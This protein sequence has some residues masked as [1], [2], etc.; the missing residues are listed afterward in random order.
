MP[1]SPALR[2]SLLAALALLC[3]FALAAP[4][5]ARPGS[6]G[7]RVVRRHFHLLVPHSEGREGLS[8]VKTVICPRH[9][10]VLGGGAEVR[11]EGVSVTLSAPNGATDGWSAQLA[12][13]STSTD[14]RAWL[15]VYAICETGRRSR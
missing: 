13:L 3:A 5:S 12:N 2:A 9:A 14:A 1:R 11:R 7:Y 6:R 8:A 4:A 15:K 10:Q